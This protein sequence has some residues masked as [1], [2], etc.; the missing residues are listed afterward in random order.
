M[1]V[2]PFGS[3]KG[4]TEGERSMLD[5]KSPVR[6][7]LGLLFYMPYSLSFPAGCARLLERGAG[8]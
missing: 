4:V 3:W 8:R 7:L 6:K 2:G 1:A 5:L